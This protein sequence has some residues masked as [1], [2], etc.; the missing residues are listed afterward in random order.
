MGKKVKPNWD[1]EWDILIQNMGLCHGPKG[2]EVCYHPYPVICVPD[3]LLG[4]GLTL[5]DKLNELDPRPGLESTHCPPVV[6]KATESHLC[7]SELYLLLIP[8]SSCVSSGLHRPQLFIPRGV[9]PRRVPLSAGLG[10]IQLRDRQG[11]VPGPVLGPRH[12]Q[13][14]DQHLLL[15]PELDRERLLFGCVFGSFPIS[16][17]WDFLFSVA[18]VRAPSELIECF[19]GSLQ[20]DKEEHDQLKIKTKSNYRAEHN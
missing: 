14:R 17:W 4:L 16:W 10:W 6:K 8:F 7:A 20:E 9:H 1:T 3:A 13:R 2:H 19:M 15:R 5:R 18:L 12:L 11:H